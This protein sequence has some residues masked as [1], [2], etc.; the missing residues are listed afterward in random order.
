[1]FRFD[2][3]ISYA[4]EEEGIAENLYQL[5]REKGVKVF[6]ARSE[7]VYLFGKSL[8]SEL[9]YIFGP[10][11]KF[12]VP[13]I[14]ENYVKKRWP[15][16]EF[17]IAKKEEPRRRFEFILPIHLDDVNLE[18]LKEDIVYIDLRK[19]GIFGSVDILIEKL[20]QIYPIE[21]MIVP[22]VWVAT[23]AV[24]IED[25]FENYEL[26]PSVPR[27][28]AYL[29]DWLEKDLM[30]RL[31]KT[32]I[33]VL[34]LLEDSRDGETFSVRVGFKWDADKY[35]L[36]FGNIDWWQVLEIDEFNEIYPDQ[37]SREIFGA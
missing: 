22:K 28:Y 3:A 37:D 16:Y 6:F 5:L 20:R 2:I 15:K 36:D 7:N 8:T 31:S 1:M 10:H 27:D 21:E 12:F 25:I 17:R 18:G 14:S 34:K 23:F 19:E 33:E 29:C 26:P 13:I 35:P 24:I 9:Q 11:T 4:S 32:S 30:N